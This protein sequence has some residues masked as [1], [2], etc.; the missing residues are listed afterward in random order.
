MHKNISCAVPA[1]NGDIKLDAVTENGKTSVNVEYPESSQL[2][3]HIPE[4]AQV[5]VNGKVI[6]SSE[7]VIVL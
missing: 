3:L 6:N 7:S 2:V 4:N 1:I 5:T